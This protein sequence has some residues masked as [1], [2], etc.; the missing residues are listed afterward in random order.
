MSEFAVG[1][2]VEWN[3]EAGIVSGVIR[4][5]HT[6]DVEFKGRMRRCSPDEPQYEIDSD[7]TDHAAMHKGSALRK[8]R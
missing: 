5:I 3:S 1:D 2:H 6:E 4:V 7:K 8:V